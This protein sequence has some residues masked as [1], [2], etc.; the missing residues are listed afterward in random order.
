M[1]YM[2]EQDI[3][4]SQVAFF[5]SVTVKG[6][7]Y[8]VYALK[9]Q[10][11]A[12]SVAYNTNGEPTAPL[13]YR[14][15]AHNVCEVREEVDGPAIDM[16]SYELLIFE[17][18]ETTDRFMERSVAY[19]ASDFFTGPDPELTPVFTNDQLAE[20][21]LYKTESPECVLP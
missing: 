14:D 1:T 11:A 17:V 19:G 7:E 18:L 12:I 20:N 4:A 21:I 3:R 15:G 5:R 16:E 6:I 9:G 2:L 10:R 13:I 8:D